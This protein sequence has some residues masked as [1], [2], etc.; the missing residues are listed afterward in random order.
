MKVIAAV[1]NS[2]YICEINHTEV[3]K[4]FDKYYGNMKPL[5][6]GT[7]LDLGGGYNFRSAIAEACK[8]MVD[9]T[10]KF[11]RSQKSLLQFAVMVSKMPNPDAEEQVELT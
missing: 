6:V 8:G 4:V 11:E 9:A 5:A 2:T 10:A 3:E 1:G 7:E